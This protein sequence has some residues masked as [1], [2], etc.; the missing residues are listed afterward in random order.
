[1]Q[2]SDDLVQHIT[3]ELMK[4]LGPQAT[5]ADPAAKPL[6]HLV[7]RR[8]DLGTPALAKIQAGFDV[9]EHRLWDE[10]LPP[11]ASVLITSLGLE[12]LVRVAGGD[13]GSTV[14]GRVLLTALLNGQPVA[15]L[16]DGLVWRRYQNTAPKALLAHYH[17]CENVL[18]SYGLKLV[19]EDEVTAA[20]T[21]RPPQEARAGVSKPAGHQPTRSP[22]AWSGGG[23]KVLSE[24]DVMAL[25]PVSGGEGQ[26]LSLSP[27]EILTPL[28]QDY[29]LSMKI[30][31]IRC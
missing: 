21:G 12:A 26:T 22:S 3:R 10:E 15:A 16:K 23:K 30:N 7:G 11:A 18:V 8:E 5:L 4:R 19:D 25:C 31:L 28:A 24:S 27:G 9:R 6:L 20:L 14:D 13:Q 17:H 1:M 2:I 29:V